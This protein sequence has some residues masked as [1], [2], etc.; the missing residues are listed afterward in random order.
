MD[1]SVPTPRAECARKD[2]WHPGERC[3]AP[4]PDSEKL[5][6]ASIKSI[7]VDESGKSFAVI[8]YSDFQERRI[9]LKQ[10]QEV[11]PIKECPRNFIFDDEDLEK[12]YFPDRKVPSSASAFNLSK[13]GDA[14]PYTINRYLRGYQREGAQFLY[15]HYVRGRGCIL[16]DDMGLGKT[17]QVISFLAAVLHKKGTREDME[18]NMP[19]FLLRSMRKELPSSV[20]K[21]VTYAEMVIRFLRKGLFWLTSLKVS[22]HGRLLWG[23]WQVYLM[24]GFHSTGSCLLHEGWRA[25]HRDW[26]KPGAQCSL[27]GRAPTT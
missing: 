13:D 27:Q 22:V 4:S 8:L 11:K 2:R 15:G 20:A 3:L 18:N 19:E 5:C 10:L 26:K 16:G 24:L 9:P 25:K 23:L 7:T 17:V 6:E 1:P 21:K 12:P 14:I